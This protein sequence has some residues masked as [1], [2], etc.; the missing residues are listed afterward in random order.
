MGV[1][2]EYVAG[3]VPFTDCCVV[4]TALK[5]FHKISIVVFIPKYIAVAFPFKCSEA[6]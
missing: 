1:V 6:R 5:S 4:F 3:C 2:L